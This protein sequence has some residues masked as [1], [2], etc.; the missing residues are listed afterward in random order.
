VEA[1]GWRRGGEGSEARGE[2]ETGQQLRPHR[3]CGKVV[4][5]E[6]VERERE[7]SLHRGSG[8]DEYSETERQINRDR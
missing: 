2:R 3:A 8:G 7:R 6:V 1:G 4:E 5:R